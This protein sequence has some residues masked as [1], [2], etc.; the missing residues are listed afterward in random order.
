[1]ASQGQFLHD[2]RTKLG[3][4]QQETADKAQITLRQYQ[5]FE[6]GERRLYTSSFHTASR[7]LGA[8]AIDLTAFAE[9]ECGEYKTRGK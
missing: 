2:A 5:Q 6:S 4:T 7:V 9:S 8:L 3:L 1:M